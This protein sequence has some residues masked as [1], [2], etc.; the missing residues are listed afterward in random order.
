MIGTLCVGVLGISGARVGG[1]N[2]Y[3]WTNKSITNKSG[4]GKNKLRRKTMC[5]SV[6]I[7]CCF[8]K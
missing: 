4:W 7:V 6:C 1:V 2:I 8:L 5:V 3:K